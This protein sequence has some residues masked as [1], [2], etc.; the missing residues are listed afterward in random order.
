MRIVSDPKQMQSLARRW[1][2][3]G[4]TIALVPTMGALHRGHES[5][6]T[7]ARQRATR[8]VA[9]IYVNPTQFAPHEDLAKYP[10]D[11]KADA[12]IC[13]RANIDVLFHPANLYT[14]DHSTW[15]EESSL[16]QDLCG[17]TRPGHFRGV[18]TV[19][20][21]LL[22]I[23]QPDLA[24]F[25]QKDAQQVA[26]I[27]RMVR[28]LYV[29]TKIISLP[30]VRDE[31]GLAFSSRNRF[32]TVAQRTNAQVLPQLLHLAVAQKNP[33]LWFQRELKRR[34]GLQLDY[35]KKFNGHL[36]AAVWVGTTR[37]IDNVPCPA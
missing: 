6:L 8:V 1:R 27:T 28:D 2:A 20:L 26:V 21:I 16:S 10:R 12:K 25:G 5:L 24:F 13:R 7:T 18:T 9:S 22:N 17:R 4:D 19:V 29:M 11:L 37:L 36:C 15:V 14:A 33:V 32:L 23:V 30:T 34:P 31:D 3:A 35:V